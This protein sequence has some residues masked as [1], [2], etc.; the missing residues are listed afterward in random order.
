MSGRRALLLSLALTGAFLL[1]CLAAFLRARPGEGARILARPAEAAEL[2][3]AGDGGLSAARELLPGETV[4]LNS[5]TREELARLD[6]V[7]ETLADAI[8]T[9]REAHG[10]FTG[11]E[12]LLA[13]PGIGEARLALFWDRLS[14]D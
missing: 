4:P 13:V 11:R 10:P 9:W 12:D 8:V 14:L 6:G 7:G 5:A 1:L 3:R 2:Y